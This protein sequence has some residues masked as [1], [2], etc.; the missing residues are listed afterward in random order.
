MLL[1]RGE[2]WTWCCNNHTSD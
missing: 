1:E 2:S